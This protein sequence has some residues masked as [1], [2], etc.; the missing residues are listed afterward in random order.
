MYNSGMSDE[1]MD[2]GIPSQITIS[3]GFQQL[4]I[5]RK[6]FDVKYIYIIPFVLIW[7]AF[8]FYWYKMALSYPNIDWLAL[9]FPILHVSMGIGLTYYV[10]TGLFNK[11]V[12]DVN[13]NSFNVRHSPFP[14]SGNK[15]LASKTL[16]QLYCK[17]EDFWSRFHGSSSFT[18][19]AITSRRENIKLLSGLENAEQAL[20]IEQEIEKFL[21][22]EDKLVKGEVR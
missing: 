1:F 17:R 21:H 4:K 14:Y 11:T 7:N 3:K 19:H 5:T 18:V 15:T 6:W 16:I 22:I 2:I 9:L 12:I 20:F 8:L 13:F 10:L